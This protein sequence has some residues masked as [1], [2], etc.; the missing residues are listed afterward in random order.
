METN[1]K[2]FNENIKEIRQRKVDINAYKVGVWI[3]SLCN[4]SGVPAGTIGLIV[5]DYGSGVTVAWDLPHQP[6]P[7][8]LTAK[9]IGA[10]WAIDHRCPLRDSFN[11]T[12]ELCY[13]KIR[14]EN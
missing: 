1:I 8:D 12:D 11:K 3:E 5:E 13:L 2:P 4:F 7:R 14:S 10:L 6:V 9:Q